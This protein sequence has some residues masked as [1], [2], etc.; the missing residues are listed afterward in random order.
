MDGMLA[1]G[2]YRMQQSFFTTHFVETE[3]GLPAQVVWARV[4]LSGFRANARLTKLQKLNRGLSL[5]LHDARITSEAEALYARY[6]SS[7]DFDGWDSIATCLLGA[8]QH[9][10]FPGRMWEVRAGEKLVGVGYFD[11]GVTSCAGI[12]NFYDPAFARHSLGLW[13]FL[14]GVRYAAE[15][16]KRHFYPG[17][18]V[19][20]MPKFDYKLL[21]G[22]E[23]TELFEPA[24][25]RWLLYEQTILAG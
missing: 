23:R 22:R 2:Y 11:E 24:S 12:L 7:I 9:D 1:R 4:C 10:Y 17:Y 3:A 16:G 5:Q 20:G 15:R 14:E 8:S 18:L 19:M 21:A 25:R 6:R 13:L